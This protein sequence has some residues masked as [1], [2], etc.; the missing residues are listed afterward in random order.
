MGVGSRFLRASSPE[1]TETEALVRVRVT[2]CEALLGEC[3]VYG[4]P[5]YLSTGEEYG[6]LEEMGVNGVEVRLVE[7]G[8]FLIGRWD[9]EGPRE[10]LVSIRVAG[11]VR[12]GV[13]YREGRDAILVGSE[14][15]VW[16]ERACIRGTVTEVVADVPD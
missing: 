10:Y 5:L 11:T 3:V 15:G 1:G 16:G 13:F 2:P 4:E 9:G 7:N 8:D 6:V 14:I 12:E